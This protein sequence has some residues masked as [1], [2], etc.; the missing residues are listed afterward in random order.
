MS[1]TGGRPNRHNEP[2]AATEGWDERSIQDLARARMEGYGFPR[3][4]LMQ[5]WTEWRLRWFGSLNF[6]RRENENARAAYERM[7]V[8]DF[9][10][11][12]A[13]QRWANWRTIPRSLNGLLPSR[14]IFALDLCCGTGHSTEVLSCYLPE[15]SRILGIEYNP[16]FVAAA[17]RRRYL[18]RDGGECEVTFRV[19]SV[20]DALRD[21]KG[22]LIADASVDL[23]GSVGAIGH[24]FG[25]EALEKLASEL[26]RVIRPG[27][28]AT[29]DLGM[30][31]PRRA[32][33]LRAFESAGFELIRT[34]SSSVLDPHLQ[35]CLR[36]ASPIR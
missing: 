24:H 28:F 4:F 10:W 2:N 12:N 5:A 13:R 32:R 30:P 20:L 26:R 14:P 23:V 18:H 3:I 25:T 8:G 27:G 33:N 11:I 15:G 17:R 6:R 16:E 22:E 7:G 35:V 21:D 34:T 9:E 29:I 1:G 31:G 36:R 19:Q